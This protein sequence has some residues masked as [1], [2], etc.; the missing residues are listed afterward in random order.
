MGSKKWTTASPVRG[1]AVLMAVCAA[2]LAFG[3][4]ATVKEAPGADSAGKE[5]EGVSKA[6]EKKAAPTASASMLESFEGAPAWMAVGKNWGDGDTSKSVAPS[7]A[8]A[9][10]GAKSLELAF[11]AMMKDKGATCFTEMPDIT[12][13]SPYEGILFDVNNPT[14]QGMQVAVAI[15]TGEGWAWFES[16]VFELPAG[17]SRDLRVDL[18]AGNL[19]TAATN[20]EFKTDLLDSDDVRRVAFKFFGPEGLEGSLFIDNIRLVK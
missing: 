20:W 2:V 17:E 6:A 14:G 16:G 9:S 7:D 13:F 18:Y 12:D 11:N 5:A 19:K 3:A 1:G 4:C 10:E 8:W 15:T